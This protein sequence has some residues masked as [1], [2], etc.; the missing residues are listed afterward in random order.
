MAWNTLRYRKKD[1]TRKKR[2]NGKADER[3]RNQKTG[4]VNAGRKRI[5]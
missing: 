2:Y 4:S 5:R 1:M 3:G